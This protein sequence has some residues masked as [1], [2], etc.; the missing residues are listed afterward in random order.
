MEALVSLLVES[1]SLASVWT[2]QA[3]ILT[4]DELPPS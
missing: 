1:T 4:M 3:S 2:S